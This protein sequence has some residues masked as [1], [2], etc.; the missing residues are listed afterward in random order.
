LT[1]LNRG[2]PWRAASFGAS[3]IT[4]TPLHRLLRVSE[5]VFILIEHEELAAIYV[6]RG[7]DPCAPD[8]SGFGFGKPLRGWSSPATPGDRNTTK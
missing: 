3:E 2:R 1:L 7:L 8:S 5:A 6:D 4:Q